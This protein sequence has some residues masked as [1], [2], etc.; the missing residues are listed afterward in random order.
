MIDIKDLKD[1]V[2]YNI[3]K[4]DKTIIVPHNGVDCDAIA[5]AIG[6]SLLAKKY[7]KD[8]N[9]VM[10]DPS[11]SIDS[12]VV[13]IIENAKK[14]FSIINLN[15]YSSIACDNDGYI[16]TTSADRTLK[17]YEYEIKLKK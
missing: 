6:L 8:S 17:V 16:L 4:T 14:D 9:I 10:N 2:E 15:K 11:T 3:N 1:K 5:S 12:S 7:K 13:K